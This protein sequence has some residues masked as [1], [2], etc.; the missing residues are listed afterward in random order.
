MRNEGTGN[1]TL[2]ALLNLLCIIVIVAAV[3]A[4]V[5]W[6]SGCPGE[7]T[8]SDSLSTAVRTD[9]VRITVPAVSDTALLR[10]DTVYYGIPV[11]AENTAPR[12]IHVHD[13][14]IKVDTL[15][16]WVSLPVTTRTYRDST[17]TAV[18]SGYR[19]S[20]DYIETYRRHTVTTVTRWRQPRFSIGAGPGLYLTP[21]G[22][23]PGI[24]ITLQ[25]N[26]YN[27]K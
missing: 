17:Y 8:V 25:Y 26:L 7:R 19:P 18:V 24:G 16:K 23:Q 21:R 11:P 20:L 14:L 22:I 5:K 1:S 6:C 13:T 27:F 10:T 12:I 4:T 9:T 2:T 15:H 3:S